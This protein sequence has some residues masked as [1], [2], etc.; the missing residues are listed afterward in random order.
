[1]SFIVI[2]KY[3][4]FNKNS[5]AKN[6]DLPLDKVPTLQPDYKKSLGLLTAYKVSDANGEVSKLSILDTRNVND[7]T[8]YQIKVTN[9]APLN[10][11]SFVFE[12]YKKK[13][14]D[15]LIKVKLK[16]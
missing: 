5:N 11:G 12:A 14:E 10:D 13:K 6:I 4:N 7:M 3:N 1:M 16:K 2:F 9:I 15:I 8:I